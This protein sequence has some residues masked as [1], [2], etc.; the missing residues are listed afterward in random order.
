MDSS[1][2]SLRA[3]LVFSF[4]GE[5]YDLDTR[6]DL[7]AEAIDPEAAPDFH[8][9]IARAA[10]IDPYSYLYEVMASHDIEFSDPSGAAC[11]FCHDGTFDW[12]GYMHNQGQAA[13]L[14]ALK[15]IAA[16]ILGLDDLSR[17]PD[18]RAALLAAYQAGKAAR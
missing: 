5:T 17:H 4:K 7:D 12:H 16:R 6:I 9:L 1:R 15:A 3:R 8:R 10:D 14:K 13:D 18:I 11:G 2:N